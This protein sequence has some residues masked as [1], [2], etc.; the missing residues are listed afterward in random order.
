MTL[1]FYMYNKKSYG[2]T[3]QRQTNKCHSAKSRAAAEDCYTKSHSKLILVTMKTITTLILVFILVCCAQ[4]LYAQPNLVPNHSFE[5]TIVP[6]QPPAFYLENFI[7]FW[8]GGLGYYRTT[9]IGNFS[10]PSNFLGYQYPKSGNAYCGIT[11]RCNGTIPAR[12]YIQTKLIQQLAIG[13]KYKV[14]FYISLADTFHNYTNSIGAY[15]ST[16]SFF[17]SYTGIIEQL[18]QIQNGVHNNLNSKTDWTLVS[19]TFVALGN[20]RYITIGNFY[21]DSLCNPISLDSICTLQ[22]VNGACC[23]YYFIDDVSVELVDETGL[24]ANGNALSIT[25]FPNP[26]TRPHLQCGCFKRGFIILC[27]FLIVTMLLCG[28]IHNKKL[29]TLRASPFLI[30]S[31]FVLWQETDIESRLSRD[32]ND[33]YFLTITVVDWV[34]LFTR[35]EYAIIVIDSLKYCIEN[36]GLVS[37]KPRLLTAL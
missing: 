6:V 34:D 35:K 12:E 5:D 19:D 32:Q 9:R 27:L 26:P 11:T 3:C 28:A 23:P 18:P 24:K 36:K 14:S 22:P 2:D 8:H 29:T 16:D 1:P 13:K 4:K 37:D 31:M 30:N 10:V 17:V 7:N 15:F 25:I 21:T 33:I 20:E